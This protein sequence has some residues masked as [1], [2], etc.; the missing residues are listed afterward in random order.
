MITLTAYEEKTLRD[1]VSKMATTRKAYDD[2]VEAIKKP[3][4]SDF[5]ASSRRAMDA[6]NAYQAVKDSIAFLME[7]AVENEQTAAA[8]TDMSGSAMMP[9][10]GV[11]PC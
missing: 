9:V 3:G 5:M 7:R 8:L 11:L 2:A 1:L 4:D 6:M 10:E